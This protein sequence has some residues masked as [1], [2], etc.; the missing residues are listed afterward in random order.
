MALC[1]GSQPGESDWAFDQFDTELSK[2]IAI[3]R[4][5]FDSSLADASGTL[6]GL[7]GPVPLGLAL[8][9]SVLT[10]LGLRP[11]LKEYAV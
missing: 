1:L 10:F 6:A 8:A 3:N 9:V 2:T 5:Y 11:R 4:K 7:D